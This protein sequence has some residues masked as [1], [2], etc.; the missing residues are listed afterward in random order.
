MEPGASKGSKELVRCDS[1]VSIRA[2]VM[3][4]RAEQSK[5]VEPERTHE[6]HPVGKHQIFLRIAKDMM[7]TGRGLHGTLRQQRIH[8]SPCSRQVRV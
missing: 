2:F 6:M 7:A 4:S 8:F 1:C 3:T 5:H